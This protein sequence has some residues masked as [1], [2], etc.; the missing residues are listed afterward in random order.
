MFKTVEA[1]LSPLERFLLCISGHFPSTMCPLQ[2]AN[3]CFWKKYNKVNMPK[4]T[5]MCPILKGISSF[6]VLHY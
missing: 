1:E 6:Y 4:D 2:L 3:N 5:M